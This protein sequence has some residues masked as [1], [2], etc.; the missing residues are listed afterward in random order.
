MPSSS[1]RYLNDGEYEGAL[2]SERK[3]L[4]FGVTEEGPATVRNVIFED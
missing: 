2:E 1:C 4:S 3:V